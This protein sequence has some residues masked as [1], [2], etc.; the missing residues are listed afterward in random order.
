MTE[1]EHLFKYTCASSLCQPVKFLVL[2]ILSH[3][4]TYK[5]IVCCFPAP[6][7]SSRWFTFSTAGS[8]GKE[9]LPCWLFLFYIPIQ[10]WVEKAG[11][12]WTSGNS[13]PQGDNSVVGPAFWRR[14]V[15]SQRVVEYSLLLPEKGILYMDMGNSTSTTQAS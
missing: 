11:P 10:P 4:H 1:V 14:G 15:A 9:F 12:F 2:L 3:I 7:R 6:E 5:E 13:H 8:S